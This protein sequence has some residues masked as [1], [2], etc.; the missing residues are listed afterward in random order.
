MD[1]DQKN[2][3]REANFPA[4]RIQQGW[5]SLCLRG[6]HHAHSS[7]FPLSP[8]WNPPP[9]A[10]SCDLPRQTRGAV[11]MLYFLSFASRP[12]GRCR[13][14]SQ[15]V[16][17]ISCTPSADSTPISRFRE[18]PTL[19]G[20]GP[21]RQADHSALFCWNCYVLCYLTMVTKGGGGG[22]VEGVCLRKLSTVRHRVQINQI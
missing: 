17:C 19:L 21:K 3:E 20:S 8:D 12:S 4:C 15:T 1:T 16:V 6:E 22:G 10:V 5:L 14:T 2:S 13:V 11:Y 9:C 7:P 18:G